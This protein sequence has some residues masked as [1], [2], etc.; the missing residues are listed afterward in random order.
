MHK[1]F[2]ELV[3]EAAVRPT[4]RKRASLNIVKF[5]QKRLNKEYKPCDGNIYANSSG[6][7][8]G[9][10][11]IC[12]TD[13]SAIRVNWDGK[14]F[15][16][17]N[18]WDDYI[19]NAIPTME[20][21]TSKIAPGQASFA[22]LLP[23]IADA[24]KNGGFSSEDDD[25]MLDDPDDELAESVNEAYEYNGKTFKTKVDIVYAMYDEGKSIDEIKTATGYPPGWIRKLIARH[26]GE[27]TSVQKSE[28]GKV[29]VIKGVAET[30]MPNKG[31]KKADAILDDTEYA[32]PDVVFSDLSQYVTLVGRRLIPALMITGQGGIGKSYTVSEILN[33]YGAKGKEYV[34]MKGRC[35]P[36]AMYKFLY[37]HY[38]QIC[39][40]DDCDSIFNSEDGMNILKGALDS[41]NPREISWMTKGPDIID[42]FGVESHEEC[43]EILSAAS[44]DR[45][46]APVTPSYFVF[47]GG[48]I[49]ISNLTKRDIYKKDRAILSRCTVIDIVL[50]AK[51][52]INRIESVLP[53]IKI[54]DIDGNNI[55]NDEGKKIVFDYIKSEEFMNNPRTRGK[56]MNFRA[57]NQI[58]VYWYAGFENWKELAFRAG[59]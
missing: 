32:D 15:H 11:Y 55:A 2:K 56:E 26:T 42:T 51:D 57:F 50:R 25:D 21:F 12:P 37:N 58:Y 35:T 46:G 41:G 54:Y 36:S 33:K 10:L 34:I 39:V 27:L 44:E 38:N 6:T 28:S 23:E 48:V 17:I 8:T 19:N 59:G 52:V 1:T 4:E 31:T 24:I 53:T 13:N 40:F 16:S 9:Y 45:K 3:N 20:I 47:K 22:R 18:V 43:E 49:F 5:L 14:T 7:Y 29:K 30:I